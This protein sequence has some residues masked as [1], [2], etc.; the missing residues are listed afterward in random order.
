MWRRMWKILQNF[1]HL[2]RAWLPWL[3]LCSPV[4]A[5]WLPLGPATRMGTNPRDLRCT[6][7]PDLGGLQVQLSAAPWTLDLPVP[8]W[9]VL[10]WHGEPATH[11][12]RHCESVS[13]PSVRPT[14]SRF[15]PP[16][17]LRRPPGSHCI[18]PSLV[19]TVET[20]TLV[21]V[22]LWNYVAVYICRCLKWWLWFVNLW[23][24][25]ERKVYDTW[26]CSVL[27][28][29]PRAKRKAL[30]CQEQNEKP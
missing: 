30:A 25:F 10:A 20:S 14:S 3:L 18:W 6:P 13:V 21:E 11:R 5:R 15:Q 16:L 17:R 2:N 29:L 8:G 28:R 1:L 12:H 4:S 9:R 19:S 7:Y 24:F 23:F 27:A 22:L 26:T